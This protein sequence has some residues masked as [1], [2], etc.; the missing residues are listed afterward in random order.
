LVRNVDEKSVPIQVTAVTKEVVAVSKLASKE[1]VQ[2]GRLGL[3]LG[4]LGMGTRKGAG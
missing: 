4:E 1:R 2:A 3:G